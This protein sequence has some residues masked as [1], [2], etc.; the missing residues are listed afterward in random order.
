VELGSVFVVDFQQQRKAQ[1]RADRIAAFRAELAE[2]EREQGLT[3]TPDQRAQLDGHHQRVLADLNQQFGA[4]ISEPERRISW[5]MRL[6]SLLGGVAFFVALFLF[7][8]RI[9]GA[10]PIAAQVAVLVFIPLLLLAATAYGAGRKVASYYL[11]LLGLATGTAFVLGLSVLGSIFNTVPSPHA[12][13]AWGAFAFL[14]AYAFGLRLLLG[15][16]L[17]L[18]CAWTATWLGARGGVHWESVLSRGG[19][20]I[21]GAA[22]LYAM[23]WLSRGRNPPDFDFVYRVC[24]A[25]V[26]LIAL[27]IL[28]KS[29]DLCCPVPATRMVETLYQIAGL[30]V[31]AG[32]IWH[33]LRLGRN[34]LVNLGGAAF[35][36]FLFVCLHGWWWDWMPRYL[37]FLLIGMTALGLL[38]AFRRLRRQLMERSAA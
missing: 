20:F 1:Q 32:V 6:V 12:L 3:L 25:A 24:G 27:L 11:A 29:A 13:L 15:A 8:Q 4:D 30:L 31:S 16:G 23:P 9:W 17:V 19:Y 22:L 5:G 2:L 36:T 28:S 26:G 33:G 37:F 14:V 18:L 35:V 10:L 21:P 38:A 34:G 7:L